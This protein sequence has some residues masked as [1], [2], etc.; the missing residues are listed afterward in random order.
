MDKFDY[1]F[2]CGIHSVTY[3]FSV[4]GGEGKGGISD[5]ANIST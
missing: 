5:D 1:T 4:G 2:G 3:V